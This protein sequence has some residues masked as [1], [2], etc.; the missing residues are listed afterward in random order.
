MKVIS[1]AGMNEVEKEKLLGNTLGSFGNI[2]IRGHHIK[3]FEDKVLSEEEERCSDVTGAPNYYAWLCLISEHVFS[4]LRHFCFRQDDLKGDDLSLEYNE[5]VT[6]FCDKCLELRIFDET[7]LEEL[8]GVV[9]KILYIRHALIHN[10]F[11]NL[12]PTGR[13][14]LKKRNMPCFSKTR[15]SRLKFN[16]IEARE[17]VLWYANPHNFRRAKEDFTRIIK[18]ACKGPGLCVGF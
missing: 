14:S 16:E 5:I 11:P 4:L 13:E 6:G 8:Y 17:I 1:T 3:Y 12:L 2:N 10:G 9:V 15:N 18:A 7:D